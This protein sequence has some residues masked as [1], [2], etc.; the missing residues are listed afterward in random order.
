MNDNFVMSNYNNPHKANRVAQSKRYQSYRMLKAQ[1]QANGRQNQPRIFTSHEIGRQLLGEEI[2]TIKNAISEYARPNHLRLNSGDVSYIGSTGLAHIINMASPLRRGEE[3]V[4][5]DF[6]ASKVADGLLADSPISAPLRNYYINKTA[7]GM[8]R[9][10]A[11]VSDVST[12]SY[13]DVGYVMHGE[14]AAISAINGLRPKFV[15]PNEVD[16][17][18]PIPKVELLL[19]TFFDVAHAEVRAV[20]AKVEAVSPPAINLS[21]ITVL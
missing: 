6:R 17:I 7:S 12:D 16:G 2:D 10:V 20:M 1:T 19:A 5:E 15:I 13:P 9:V 11:A 3:C 21:P 18:R 8:F 14:Q 4:V